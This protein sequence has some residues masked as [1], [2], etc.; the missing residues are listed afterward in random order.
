MSDYKY[1]QK[2]DKEN[3]ARAVG[4]AL[5]ISTKQSVEVCAKLR[6]KKLDSAKKILADAIKK[7]RPIRFTRFHGDTG[8]KRGKLGPGRY[9]VKTCTEILKLLNA[10]ETNAQHKG[11]STASLEI[12]H[13]C[14]H[15][16]GKQWHYGRFR[17]R[18]M[19][20]T[21]VEIYLKETEKKDQK[22]KIERKK[23]EKNKIE[24]EKIKEN[25]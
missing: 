12:C 5:P 23:S 10:A 13:I 7:K 14:A 24:E 4:I 17:R 25:N 3:M 2:Y 6:N 9:C 22:I 11:L 15:K 20:R 8:H 21:H 19:K 18:R 16:A 1:A